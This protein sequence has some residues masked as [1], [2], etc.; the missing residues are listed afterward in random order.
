MT[1]DTSRNLFICVEGPIGVGKSTAVRTLA[2][3]LGYDNYD[4]PISGAI[5]RLR[6]KFY[7]DMDKYAGLFQ[8]KVFIKRFYQH[9]RILLD[10]TNRGAIQDRSIFGDK[11][12]AYMLYE[13]R[14]ISDEELEVYE[15]L[16]QVFRHLIVNPD[17]MFFLEAD[18]EI[19]LERINNQRKREE[20]SGITGEYLEGLKIKLNMLYDE[21]Q[22]NGVICHKISWD[23]PNIHIPAIAN[24]I[25]KTSKLIAPRWKRIK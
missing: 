21:M 5:E 14:K 6:K 24:I 17:I 12:F 23:E 19:L 25:Q 10:L 8:I 13:S 4:E 18:T 1:I 2:K 22:N 11:C 15:E 7:A 9:Q 16:W 3:M 20:E